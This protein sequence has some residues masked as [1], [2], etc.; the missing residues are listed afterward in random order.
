[1]MIRLSRSNAW[2]NFLTKKA[3]SFNV[4]AFFHYNIWP[5]Q[6]EWPSKGQ[7]ISKGHF[8]FNS[9][10]K[11]TRNFCPSRLEQFSSSFFGKIGDTKKTFRN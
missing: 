1:M 6:V 8:F 4:K 9:P 2:M 7:L 5:P 11:R 10:T 3:K